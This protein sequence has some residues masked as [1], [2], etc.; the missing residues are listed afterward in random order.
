MPDDT[1]TCYVPR[2][3]DLTH[4]A[5]L[6]FSNLLP[7]MGA[8]MSTKH[9]VNDPTVL[10][11]KSLRS[12]GRTNPLL[13]V[14]VDNKVVFQRFISKRQVSLVSGGGSGHEPSFGGL[15]GPGLLTAAVAGTIFASPSAEQIRTCI[16]H[17][18]DNREG[19]LVIIMNYTGDGLQ[20]GMAVEKAKANGIDT[21][22]IIVG[23]DVGV[24]RARSGRVGRRGIAGTV[25]VQKVAGAA[26]ASG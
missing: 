23:D 17:R 10:V 7:I 1:L 8:P 25:L 16:L 14:D 15:V 13:G 6:N 20:F 21:E 5:S 26:A 3:S 4:L 2:N 22:M 24:G 18:V 9:F 12:L 19:V 11:K